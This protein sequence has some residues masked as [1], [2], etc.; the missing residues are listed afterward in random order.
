MVMIPKQPSPI[1][2]VSAFR[3]QHPGSLTPCSVKVRESMS[4]Q[5]TCKNE[6]M[7]LKQLFIDER[8]RSEVVKTQM[9]RIYIVN[10]DT[11]GCAFVKHVSVAIAAVA[12]AA[13]AA[14]AAAA[15]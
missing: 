9:H 6:C 4:K 8:A 5:T 12:V 3:T 7:Q 2:V 15:T 13:A 11:L 1:K 10:V 14:A